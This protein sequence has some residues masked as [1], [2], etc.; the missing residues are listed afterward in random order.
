MSSISSIICASASSDSG[1]ARLPV[2]GASCCISKSCWGKA[3]GRDNPG[4]WILEAG[5]FFSVELSLL[6]DIMAVSDTQRTMEFRQATYLKVVKLM[7][8]TYSELAGHVILL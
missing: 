8:G 5:N 6:L 3:A 7:Q 1:T 2:E 4:F